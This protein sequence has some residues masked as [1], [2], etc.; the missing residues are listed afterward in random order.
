MWCNAR[1][2][3]PPW[4]VEQIRGGFKLIDANGQALERDG[5]LLVGC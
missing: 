1:K 3:P 5:G 4:T 2:F